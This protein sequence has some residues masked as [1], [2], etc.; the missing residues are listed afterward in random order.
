V[1]SLD[2]KGL[3]AGCL[4]EGKLF[5]SRTEPNRVDH[6]EID[7][8][9]MVKLCAIPKVAPKS[10]TV[11][12]TQNRLYYSFDDTVHDLDMISGTARETNTPGTVVHGHPNQKYVFSFYRPQRD[13]GSGLVV[14]DGRVYEV[15]RGF[16]WLQSPL[17][18]SVATPGELLLAEVRDNAASN[19]QHLA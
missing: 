5:L 12:P 8:G 2:A 7:S 15:R 18:K 3:V 1:K 17:F 19:G 11:F 4:M 10:F 14:I 13:G 16:D 6:V 9:K